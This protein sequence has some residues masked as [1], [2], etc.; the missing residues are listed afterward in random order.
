MKY[1]RQLMSGMFALALLASGTSVF[2]ADI[3]ITG[4]KAVQQTSQVKMKAVEDGNKDG[5]VDAKDKNGKDLETKDDVV[6]KVTPVKHTKG[7]KSH[8]VKVTTPVV[9]PVQ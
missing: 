9:K 3:P 7:K 2:A 1:K 4:S 8:K 5:I 6:K